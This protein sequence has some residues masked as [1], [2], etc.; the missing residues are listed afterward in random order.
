ML[1]NAEQATKTNKELLVLV[2]CTVI[3]GYFLLPATIFAS[4]VGSALLHPSATSARPLLELIVVKLLL[5]FF[6][7]FPALL[8][9]S[10]VGGWF[11]Y[12]TK[13][14]RAALSFQLLPA[15]ILICGIFLLAAQELP[16]RIKSCSLLFPHSAADYQQIGD[17][18]YLREEYSKA[19]IDFTKAEGLSTPGSPEYLIA[20]AYRSRAAEAAQKNG[21]ARLCATTTTALPH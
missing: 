9:V 8:L 17:N 20:N 12:A 6:I 7:L 18:H 13:K 1:N 10:I 3:Y 14:T 15:P 5:G 4:Q 2:A 16:W 19:A 11:L 21:L